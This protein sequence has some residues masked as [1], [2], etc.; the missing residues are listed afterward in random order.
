ML[1]KGLFLYICC[2]CWI[3]SIGQNLQTVLLQNFQAGDQLVELNI[4]L[5][6]DN[7]PYVFGLVK[8]GQVEPLALNVRN[9]RHYYD[10]R[11]LNWWNGNVEYL[12]TNLPKEA[13]ISSRLSNPTIRSEFDVLMYTE[14]FSPKIVNFATP[15]QIRGVNF[16]IVL[17]LLAVVLILL[18]KFLFKKSFIT[19]G[20]I[21]VLAAVMLMDIRNIVDHWQ[22]YTDTERNHPYVEPLASVQDFVAKVRPFLKGNIWT[23]QGGMGDEYYKL[24]INYAL[25]DLP[26]QVNLN[27]KRDQSSLKITRKPK[28]NQKILVEDK[29]FYLV[30]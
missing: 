7:I 1:K 22:I 29:G 12:M 14:A 15:K 8:N 11:D 30:Q 9:G 21:G 4:N 28:Q 2:S 6:S 26:F 20:C 17:F 25:A 19:A 23:F 10:F 5:Q 27:R 18:F 16:S 24:Y 13:I 3:V